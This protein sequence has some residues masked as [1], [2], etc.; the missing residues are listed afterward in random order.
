MQKSQSILI[1]GVCLVLML[2]SCSGLPAGSVKGTLA[3]NETSNVNLQLLMV[4]NQ[5][6]S[7]MSVEATDIK[8][9]T[10]A[11]GSFVFTKVASGKYVILILNVSFSLGGQPPSIELMIIRD[12]NGDGKPFLFDVPAS[13]GV[14]LGTLT[15][16]SD[17]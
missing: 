16:A 5:N 6:G 14:D 11:K 12:P 7:Q 8:T 2:S 1:L 13:K 15:K 3:G 17:Q 10:D 4:T 9:V